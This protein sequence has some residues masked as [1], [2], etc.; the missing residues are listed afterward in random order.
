MV[1]NG[2]FYVWR[3]AILAVVF[4]HGIAAARA[5]EDVFLLEVPD[6]AWW[7]GCFG[8]ATGNLIGF[9]DRNGFP[10]FYT[11]PTQN[12]VAPLN[13]RESQG[14]AG[15]RAM[16]ASEAGVDGRPPDQPG[17]MDDY[18]IGY[19]SVD[20]DPYLTA[21]R[22]EHPPDCIGDFIGLSQDKWI[23]MNGEC[24]GN[25]DAYSFVYWDHDG[26]RRVNYQPGPEA[27][28]PPRDIPSG[29]RQWT[30]WRGYSA[31]VFSQLTDFNPAVPA[32]QGFTFEELRAEIDSGYP[33]LLFM[34]PFRSYSRKI[35]GR[36]NVNA[37]IHGMLAYGYRIESDGRRYVRYRTSW[38]SGDN[39]FSEWTDASWTPRGLLNLPLRGVI[40][41]HPSPQIIG[42]E[43]HD[44]HLTIRWHGP[45]AT[46]QDNIR[47]TTRPVHR[48][49]V[50]FATQLDPDAFAPAGPETSDLSQTLEALPERRGFYR[51]Q[52]LG[53][54]ESEDFR[55]V[56]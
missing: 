32:G 38:A 46:L 49:R 33:V 17:H 14:N 48:Y 7:A 52:L 25:I 19:E 47:G 6:Y 41:Y 28:L 43:L 12:G 8:T 22:Q 21:G 2:K 13:S 53:A 36:E 42:V 9:W 55:V 5:V 18:Y 31:D 24:D 51:L 44:G 39:Q 34:Q 23:D 27:G 29:L 15:I 30:K 3:S 4:G 16:W 26:R 45:H 1:R 37:S 54:S 10:E 56:P 40:G 11:G 50:E 35:G 20:P